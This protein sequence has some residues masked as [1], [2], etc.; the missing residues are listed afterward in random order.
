VFDQL[1]EFVGGSGGVVDP[2]TEL[3]T[4]KILGNALFHRK[5]VPKG[6]SLRRLWVDELVGSARGA[7]LVFLDPDCGIEG[8]RL[9]NKHVALAEIAALR[10]PG[11]ALIIGHRQSGRRSE[12]KFLADQMR[13]LGCDP[14]EIIRLRLGTSRLYVIA[15]HDSVMAELVATFARKSGNRAQHY[16]ALGRVPASAVSRGFI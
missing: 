6:G 8:K 3:N 1:A 16:K 7:N 10:L 4:R 9:T 14:I 11:R 2:L 12:V 15:S 5:E 13:S